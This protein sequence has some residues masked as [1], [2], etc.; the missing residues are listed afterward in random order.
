MGL[1]F[2]KKNISLVISLLVII[3]ITSCANK[4][5]QLGKY[6]QNQTSSY[7]KDQIKHQFFLIGDAG[8]LKNPLAKNNLNDLKNKFNKDIPSSLFFLGDNLYPIG[9]K[10]TTTNTYALDQQINLAKNFPGNAYFITGNHDWY[11]GYKGVKQQ[12]KYIENNYKPK[13]FYP[14]KGCGIDDI[15]ISDNLVVITIDSQWYLTDWDKNPGINDD[16]SIRTRDEFLDE[17]DALINKYQNK[18]VLVTIHHPLL[19][20]SEHGG[21][22]SLK[23]HLFPYK[24]IPLPVLGS[25]ITYVRKTSGIID[26]DLQNK[27]YISLT[28]RLKT[29]TQNKN[30]VLFI[31][32]HDH[33]LQYI[34]KEGIKQVI[35]GSGSYSDA[36]HTKDFE[37]FALGKIGHAVLDVLK[38]GET[39]IKFYTA[40]NPESPVFTQ[41]VLEKLPEFNQNI[42]EVK[43]KTTIS[44]IYEPELTNKTKT[45]KFLWGEH[46][47]NFY[48]TKIKFNNFYL[49]DEFGGLKP[50]ISGGGNQ[51]MSLR[52]VSAD[53]REFAMRALKKSAPRFVQKAFLKDKNIE[54]KVK[55]TYAERLI[56]D[57]YT[58]SHPYTPL[59]LNNFSEAI[60]IYHTNPQVFYVPKQDALGYYNN[61]Y[62]DAIYM[63]EERINKSQLNVESFGNP[64]NI[65]STPDM[66]ENLRKDEKYSVDKKMYLKSRLFDFLIGDWDRHGDQWRWAEFKNNDSIF[67]RPIPRDRD[68]AFAK[69]DGA[70]LTVLRNIPPMRHMQPYKKSFAHPR[71]INKTAF[72]MDIKFLTDVPEN[73]WIEAANYIQTHITDQVIFKAFN[74]LPAEVNNKVSQDIIEILK[75]RRE[76]L[77]NYAL[78]YRN[79]LS[80]KIIIAGT[81]KKDFYNITRLT[82]G[83]VE[84]EVYRNKKNGLELKSKTTYDHKLTK[85]IWIYGLDDADVFKISGSKKAKIKLRLI[86]GLDV[87]T[88]EIEN[89]K[90]VKIYDFKS[91]ENNINVSHFGTVLLN[92]NYK[93]NQYDWKKAPINIFTMVP[94]AGYNPDDGVLLGLQ[95]NY[96]I[97]NFLQ[98]PFGSKHSLGFTFTTNTGG[99]NVWYRGIFPNLSD[100]WRFEI[101]TKYTSPN[102]AQNFF[103][104]GNETVNTEKNSSN[105]FRV[106]METFHVDPSYKLHSEGGVIFGF[107][108]TF[109]YLKVDKTLDRYIMQEY[110]LD[111]KLFSGAL[112][113]TPKINFDFENYNQP[114]NPSL[115]FGFHLETGIKLNLEE[116][117]KDVPYLNTSV[118]FNFPLDRLGKVVFAT[119]SKAKFI[120]TDKYEFFQGATLGGDDDLRGF[121][122]ERFL[123]DRSF[124]QSTDLRWNLGTIQKSIAPMEYG[125]F[126]GTDF[127]RVWLSGEHS[128]KWY[129][130][131]GAGVWLSIIDSLT[132]H[133]AYFRSQD[134]GRVTGGVGF[135]F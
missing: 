25:L 102:F 116:I 111:P 114:H 67:Y 40:E 130:T 28:N 2:F 121:R 123:G 129:H 91:Q 58:T 15:K 90:Q 120:F 83:N 97:N 61:D 107:S 132:G 23:D 105:Y 52:L 57:F 70:I 59:I 94:Q 33:T 133:V 77:A 119:M 112:Y 101:F 24:N 93:L 47:R 46:Y 31:S 64:D 6:T 39:W 81:D 87:D 30:N 98:E 62:G 32:G 73:D 80:K 71:W 117:K 124:L 49:E 79:Y 14:R 10:D 92:D 17:F 3:L 113:V 89:K 82:N 4:K 74:E 88:Y 16:C 7:T 29:A 37:S 78:I 109:D 76:Q 22:F 131:F 126:A 63:I 85:E 66:M 20:N 127:G 21:K 18:T 99:A 38:N 12:T 41:K 54:E 122:R 45:Y 26:Q 135:K 115:G 100:N 106:R 125:V 103:G 86:G 60:G 65:L 8:D 36:S 53:G 35:V 68:Q 55:G 118:N 27:K 95:A 44:S 110:N 9:F 108:S 69:I 19:S 134:G 1:N 34:S 72:S 128:K 51:T 42:N 56:Y 5:L 48:S 75:H 11:S 84:I 13:S 43:T 96:R 50:E 104:F